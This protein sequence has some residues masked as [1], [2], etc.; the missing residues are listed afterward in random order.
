MPPRV[1]FVFQNP[2]AELWRAAEAGEAPD[3]VVHGATRLREHGFDVRVHDPVLTRTWSS[4]LTWRLRELVLPFELRG[5]GV[6]VTPLSRL[7]PLAA[8]AE[9][10]P[11]V[12]VIAYDV[13]TIAAR[14]SLPRR[15]V[16]TASL[17]A[18]AAVVCFGERQRERVMALAGLSP[19]RVHTVL[20]GVDEQYFSPREPVGEPYVLAVGKDLARD[21]ATFAAAL[22]GLD[23]RAELVTLPRNLVGV[24]L[25]PGVRVRSGISYAELRDLYA[26]AACVVLPQRRDDHP[27]GSEAGGLTAL[28][29]ALAMGKPV[30]ASERAILFDYVA[31]DREALVVPPEDP[32]ALREALG[33]V[34]GDPALASGL[35]RAARARV[36]AG[37]TTRHFAERLVPIL[38]AAARS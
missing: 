20:L 12:V 4:P 21:Y 3:S 31:E 25:P 18:A 38:R 16:L 15:R 10:G 33:R 14:S 29:E 35:G 30:V 13:S 2:H 6:I 26:G 28:L 11:Q 9:H 37:L 23:L 24:E 7:L 36:E 19:E 8:R 22:A 27:H 32:A 34:L 1:A 5:T 17:R